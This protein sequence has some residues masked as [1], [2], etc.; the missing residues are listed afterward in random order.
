MK[1]KNGILYFECDLDNRGC[2]LDNY[3]QRNNILVWPSVEDKPNA[4][5]RTNWKNTC[6]VTSLIMGLTYSGFK[7][8]AGKYEQP[9]DNL[10]E[11]ILTNKDVLAKYQKECPAMYNAW[12]KS[13]DGKCNKSELD[14]AYP[15]TELHDYLSYGANLWVGTKATQFSTKLNFKKSLWRYMVTDNKPIVVSTNFGGL[16]HIVT[17]TGVSYKKEDYQRGKFVSEKTKEVPEIT[18]YS[19]MVDDSWGKFNPKTNKYDLPSGGNDIEVPWQVVVKQFKPYNS[20]TVK[21]GHTFNEPI[22]K[23]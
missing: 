7:L 5:Y 16:G 23:I 12:I 20:E 15:P 3:S 11:F 2:E 10:G 19:V 21:W 1:E 14:N 13:L 9:E 6:N 18:P 8:P 17:V 4:Q 22:A